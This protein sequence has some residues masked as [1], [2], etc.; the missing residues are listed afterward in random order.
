MLIIFVLISGFKL[1]LCRSRRGIL[2]VASY[3]CSEA[4]C[5][6]QRC[7]APRTIMGQDRTPGCVDVRQDVRQDVSWLYTV[8]TNSSDVKGRGNRNGDDCFSCN[9]GGR[10]EMALRSPNWVSLSILMQCS[11]SSRFFMVRCFERRV[12]GDSA[13]YPYTCSWVPLIRYF[14]GAKIVRLQVYLELM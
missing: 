5:P 11:L 4:S 6:A 13:I 3:H 7:A 1:Y 10:F 14:E 8:V 2:Y 9:E 12:A